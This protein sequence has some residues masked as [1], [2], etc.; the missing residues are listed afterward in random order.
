MELIGPC[1]DCYALHFVS[2][3]LKSQNQGVTRLGLEPQGS[4]CQILAESAR[5]IFAFLPWNS[6]LH[7]PAQ[8]FSEVQ[9]KYLSYDD[10]WYYICFLF[11]LKSPS[12]FCFLSEIAWSLIGF[13]WIS[14]WWG[15]CKNLFIERG[16]VP[17]IW[18][19]VLRSKN[20]S[21]QHFWKPWKV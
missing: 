1:R 10:K 15:T 17:G 19:F 4:D 9:D 7:Q 16:F 8:V 14:I 6:Y 13:M 12:I 5:D 11:A 18:F 20:Y 21:L 2:F 3:S